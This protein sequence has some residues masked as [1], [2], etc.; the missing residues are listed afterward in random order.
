MY[1]R[2]G[3]GETFYNVNHTV[4]MN[5][6]EFLY[7]QEDYRSLDYVSMIVFVQK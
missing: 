6:N 7:F 3:E 5:A 4:E 1:L 2:E